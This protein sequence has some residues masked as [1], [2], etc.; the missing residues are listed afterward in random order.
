MLF[1][2]LILSCKFGWT[3][4]IISLHLRVLYST[5]KEN[6]DELGGKIWADKQSWG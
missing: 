4:D 6:M 5:F 2:G 1:V 3:N